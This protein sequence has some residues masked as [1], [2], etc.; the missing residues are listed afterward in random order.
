MHL[1]GDIEKNL[2]PKKDFSQMFSID[3]WNLNSLVT[4]NFTKVALL[5]AYLSVQ[6]FDIFCISETYLS[7]S[8][9][10]DDDSLQIPAYDL[11]R[12]DHPSNSKRGGIAIYYK[13]YK[14]NYKI[15]RCK[16]LEWKYST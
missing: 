3:H 11:I 13:I 2:G 15:N 16:L 4:N 1:S 7:S 10:E 6:R 14:K 8:I 5:K 9:T 12:S